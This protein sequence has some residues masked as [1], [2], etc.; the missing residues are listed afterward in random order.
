M[1]DNPRLIATTEQ[2][3]DTNCLHKLLVSL[4]HCT[5]FFQA[6]F[7]ANHG[8]LKLPCFSPII[9]TNRGNRRSKPIQTLCSKPLTSRCRAVSSCAT[10]P[11]C[12]SRFEKG[13]PSPFP[14]SLSLS[15]NRR[16]RDDKR[17][18]VT[19]KSV[20]CFPLE[21][22]GKRKKKRKARNIN[23]MRGSWLKSGVAT[24]MLSA[25]ILICSLS[26][27][28][29][30]AEKFKEYSNLGPAFYTHTRKCVYPRASSLP[31]FMHRGVRG[32]ASSNL[33]LLGAPLLIRS[34][35]TLP[36]FYFAPY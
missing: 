34:T 10:W 4:S 9:V 13:L 35:S 20:T 32:C 24:R 23:S 22:K 17:F 5:P 6:R 15:L 1:Y 16:G 28:R 18:Q 7:T 33:R 11:S 30:R 31:P 25:P 21:K 27:A 19:R 3:R 12:C 29:I 26:P 36:L 2:R 14:L 8:K